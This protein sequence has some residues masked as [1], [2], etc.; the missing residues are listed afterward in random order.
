MVRLLPTL[1]LGLSLVAPGCGEDTLSPVRDDD[2]AVV[3]D[4][5]DAVAEDDDDA[6]ER[7]Y[8]AAASFAAAM[9]GRPG[10]EDPFA[11][12]T[13]LR[14][15]FH[16]MYWGD[17]DEGPVCRFQYEIQAQARFEE[18]VSEDCGACF[19]RLEIGRGSLREITGEEGCQDL[20]PEV[21]LSFLL[22]GRGS[23]A[24]DL[25]SV[26]LVS[27]RM[28]NDEERELGNDLTTRGVVR[29]Y[30]NAG[31]MVEYFGLVAGDGWLGKAA[32]LN[33]VARPWDE[34][35]ALPMFALYRPLSDDSD[36]L[37]RGET[38]LA[39]LWPVAL[40]VPGAP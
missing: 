7:P 13:D 1:V 6:T 36:G 18:S 2:D 15:V 31:F 39:G 26:T 27:V 10:A 40:G 25:H 28:L 33:G 8:V 34:S 24:Q 9:D 3:G 22:S 14:G 20:P 19:G 21:D 37:L 4:D 30:A 16:L 17:S 32:G 5:D 35:N 23:T 12:N 29:A 38:F 11:R